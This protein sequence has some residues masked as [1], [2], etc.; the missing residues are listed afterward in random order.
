MLCDADD[1]ASCNE[2]PIPSLIG[3]SGYP[4]PIETLGDHSQFR[5]RAPGEFGMSEH[6]LLRPHQ[7]L[8]LSS[9]NLME[10]S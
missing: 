8:F 7:F 6:T 1:Q 3:C 2:A 9:E 10:A 4:V 5:L